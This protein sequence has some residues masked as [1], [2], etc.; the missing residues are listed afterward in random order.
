MQQCQSGTFYPERREFQLIISVAVPVCTE[1]VGFKGQG[2]RISGVEQATDHG[3]Y[4]QGT[5]E[6]G[7]ML[8]VF[9]AVVLKMDGVEVFPQCGQ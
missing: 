5:E 6:G 3:V 2:A 9:A 1:I 8:V 4:V 7:D